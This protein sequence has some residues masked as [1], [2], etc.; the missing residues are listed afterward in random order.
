MK[1]ESRAMRICRIWTAV[2]ERS[3]DTALPIPAWTPK[4]MQQLFD[5]FPVNQSDPT[6][7]LI[8]IAFP[9]D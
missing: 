9:W 4:S 5:S 1:A 2:A 3:A 8:R 6:L 7:I